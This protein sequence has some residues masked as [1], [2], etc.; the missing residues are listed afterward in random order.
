VWVRQFPDKGE[1]GTDEE[2]PN[3]Y[4]TSNPNIGKCNAWQ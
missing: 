4:P 3:T 1:K 2:D